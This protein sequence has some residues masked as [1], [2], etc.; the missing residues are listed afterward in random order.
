MKNII[1]ILFLFFI[2][3]YTF[4][5]RSDSINAINSAYEESANLNNLCK[6]WGFLKYYHPQVAKGKFDWDKELITKIPQIYDAKSKEEINTIYINWIN[7]LGEVKKHK[8][9]DVADSLKFNLDLKWLNDTICFNAELIAKLN[10]IKENRSKHQYYIRKLRYVDFKNEKPYNE[11]SYPDKYYRLLGLFRYWNIINYYFPYKYLINE[12]WEK[13]LS[14]MIPVFINAKDEIE[15]NRAI[16]ELTARIKDSHAFYSNN[17]TLLFFGRNW[18]PF[19]IKIIDNKAVITDFLNDSLCKLYDLQIGDV[20]LKFDGKYISDL[21][22]E[23]SKYIAASNHSV[24]LRNMAYYLLKSDYNFAEITFDRDNKIETKN[25]RL[26]NGFIIDE[27]ES[28]PVCKELDNN[29]GYVNMGVLNTK[30][31]DSVMQ[32]MMNKK[33]IIFDIRNYPKGTYY[34]ISKYLNKEVKAFAKFTTQDMSYPGVFK[35]KAAY[36]CGRKPLLQSW[37]IQSKHGVKNNNYFKGK[38]VLLINEETQSHAEFS[39]MA[40]QTA[41]DVICIGSQTAGADGNCTSVTL[42][43]AYKTT[44]TGLGVYYPDGRETQRIGINPDIEVKPSIEGIRKHKDEV[45]ERAI[46]YINKL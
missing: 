37:N 38:V 1:L 19:E 30:Q 39:C 45:L 16:M 26:Y 41:P 46:E 44:F 15:Y 33:A 28:E 13:V 31:V 29:I 17:Y 42:P 36:Y 6:I 8:C 25:I 20:I 27:K 14:E 43:G 10:F 32:L 18:V 35:W 9:K 34:K 21:I 12:N 22:S 3:F 24:L 4:S 40:L 7:S 2:S 23:K 11:M 5:L